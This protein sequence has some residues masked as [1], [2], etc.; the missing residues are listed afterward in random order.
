M[1]F[2][3]DSSN[4]FTH[5]DS[6]TAFTQNVRPGRPVAAL[7]GSGLKCEL[8]Q[9]DSVY[10][11]KGDRVLLR[12]GT[13]YNLEREVGSHSYEAALIET[14]FWNRDGDDGYSELQI[15]SPHM[16]AAIKAIVPEYKDLNIELRH[17][18]IRNEPRCL[19][20]YRNE[21]FLH[22]Q[23]LAADPEAQRHVSFL[24]QYMQ[25]TL[26]DAIYTFTMFV[27]FAVPSFP[28][29]LDF[30]N[31]WM[32]FKGG[33]LVV[34]SERTS[35]AKSVRIMEFKNMS[36]SCRCDVP[37]CRQR[38]KWDIEG[39]RID[40]DGSQFGYIDAMAEIK[41]YE[42]CRN[43]SDLIVMPL[44]YHPDQAK[45]RTQLLPRGQKFVR[46]QGSHY[47]RYKG[48]AKVLGKDRNAAAK[49]G[50]DDL[51]PVYPALVCERHGVSVSRLRANT[52]LKINGRIVIDPKAFYEARPAHGLY[53]V[54]SK[55]KFKVEDG[56]LPLMS[57]E[58]YLICDNVVAGFALN[59]KKWGY[60]NV[61]LIQDIEFDNDA[62]KSSLILEE[63]YK[64]LIVSLIQVHSV[65]E[66]DFD[67]VI[68]GKGKGI[69][70]LL[71]GDP[72]VGK[73]LT[74]GT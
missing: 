13:K 6:F 67:D 20:H 54:P 36:L 34:I 74:A 45:I 72:G 73:T 25:Q 3:L 37:L 30:N 18:T 39:Y 19:F 10:N 52:L 51:F 69:V 26:S 43:L 31:L 8:K 23:A 35:F 9:F 41:F 33:D 2:N 58:Q 46:L 65:P 42:G 68:T 70:L 7:D 56:A 61:E 22:G 40:F 12:S 32:I 14:K 27:E 38:H 15:R 29:A 17:V 57:E 28:P 66:R 59:E 4:I 62:F 60:F 71:H 48:A 21:L 44:H 49:S 53:M 47:C 5:A 63:K 16:K 1:D 64:K 55:T 24:L 11:A 50:E